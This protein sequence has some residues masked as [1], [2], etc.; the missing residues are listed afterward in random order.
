MPALPLPPNGSRPEPFFSS[1]DYGVLPVFY[2]E[3]LWRGLRFS[4]SPSLPSDPSTL[5]AELEITYAALETDASRD[6]RRVCPGAATPARYVLSEDVV[7]RGATGA[8][9]WCGVGGVLKAGVPHTTDTSIVCAN[10]GI[11]IA[12]LR[13]GEFIC[14][15]ARALGVGGVWVWVCSV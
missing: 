3:A 9:G 8:G 10:R 12:V 14:V 7:V 5:R 15:S 11:P 4:Y 6:V 1:A 2:C 13:P